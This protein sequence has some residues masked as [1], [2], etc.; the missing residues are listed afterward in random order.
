MLASLSLQGL[1]SNPALESTA[2]YKMN[3]NA[4]RRKTSGSQ[5]AHGSSD[6]SAASPQ[7]RRGQGRKDTS[8]SKKKKKKSNSQ[9][10]SSSIPSL[11][12]TRGW[13]KHARQ[14]VDRMKSV[15]RTV[16]QQLKYR[17]EIATPQH[18]VRVLLF[19]MSFSLSSFFSFNSS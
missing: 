11:S 6:S 5:D 2:K 9:A 4:Q 19:P 18:L 15:S 8:V 10:G 17:W 12:K 14:Q 16:S 13:G 7:V 3:G 1:F